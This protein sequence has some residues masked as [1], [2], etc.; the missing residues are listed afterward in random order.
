MAISATAFGHYPPCP[1]PDRVAESSWMAHIPFAFWIIRELRPSL[2]TELGTYSGVSFCAF[3]QAISARGLECNAY[4][5]DLWKGDANMGE[6]GEKIYED[7]RAYVEERYA[8]FAYLIRSSFDDALRFF[9]DKAIDLLHLDGFHGKEAI[10]HDFESWLPKMSERGVVLI[11]DICARIPGFGGVEAW[12]EISASH[13]S[14]AFTHGYGLGMVALGEKAPQ[15][16]RDMTQLG[17]DSAEADAIRGIFHTQGK[18]YEKIFS[19]HAESS[20]L[21]AKD[22]AWRENLVRELEKEKEKNRLKEE[23]LQGRLEQMKERLEQMKDDYSAQARE[24]EARLAEQYH[25]YNDSLSWRM[26]A[27]MRKIGGIFR[28]KDS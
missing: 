24:L 2:L 5:V 17:P 16:L 9:P 7:L 8:S 13:P 22:L 23:E 20:E 19:M 26:T 15:V 3:C 12:A 10:L 11:H 27:P 4:G 1:P 18:I 21:E 28:S 14:F 6:Y 25:R